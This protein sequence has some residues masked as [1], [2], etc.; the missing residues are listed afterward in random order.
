MFLRV[1]RCTHDLPLLLCLSLAPAL[2]A[3]R[4]AEAAVAYSGRGIGVRAVVG[5]GQTQTVADTGAL[6]DTGGNLSDHVVAAAVPGLLTAAIV[7]A[8]TSGAGSQSQTQASITDLAITLPG[9]AIAVDL[10]Q[11]VATA[12]CDG[13]SASVAGGATIASLTINGTPIVVNGTPNQTIAL[14]LGLGQI[15]LNQQ[16]PSASGD[17]GFIEVNALR[18]QVP[19][20]GIDVALASSHADVD[21]DAQTS[22]TAPILFSGRATV[23][24]ATVLGEHDELVDTGPLPSA[25][26]LRQSSLLTANLPGL[27]T[28][29]T[30]AA[31]TSGGGA[32]SASDATVASVALTLAGIGIS[33]DVVTSVAEASCTAGGPAASGDSVVLNL[34]I[35][36]NVIPITGTPNQVVALPLGLGQIVINEQQSTVTAS[37]AEM[38][39]AALHVIVNGIADV[40]ISRTHADVTCIPPPRAY[41]GRGVI[42]EVTTTV[43]P[44]VNTIGD[45]GALPVQGGSLSSS[46]PSI[47]LPGVL[48]ATLL[49]SSASGAADQSSAAA[50]LA[51]VDLLAGLVQATVVQSSAT[52][53]C[54]GAS[55]S[56]AGAS[57]IASLSVAGLPINVT[58]Q[59]NQVV[60]LIVGS[61][62]LNQ[63][64]GGAAGSSG[65]LTVNAL[66]LAVAGVADVVLGSS[67][68]DIECVPNALPPCPTPPAPTPTPPAP[69]PTPA[70]TAT[71]RPTPTAPLG[72]P[73]PTAGVC[74]HNCPDKIR[75]G[76][77]LDLL[78]VKSGFA[79]STVLNPSAEGFRIVLRNANGVIWQAT[80]QPGDLVLRGRKFR[81]ADKGARRGQGIRGGL[82]RVEISSANGGA[83]TRV[84]VQ[85]FADLSAATLAT[86]TVEIT[87]GNDTIAYTQPWQ[88][89][90]YGWYL[91][92]R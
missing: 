59:P 13:T 40:A 62:V 7:D 36:G 33:A 56:V 53:T 89:K 67:H 25:G 87:V 45:T 2:L 52:A 88:Q 3:G 81:F 23:F 76:S 92:H 30:L 55:A 44:L 83:G 20:L 34:V 29:A 82:S 70:V 79:P 90:P 64:T 35:A 78:D 1:L 38:N 43:P 73:Q 54:N 37:S 77:G 84:N 63:Q 22:C 69:T 74:H 11:S 17:V 10:L 48:S 21:C 66:H 80:L 4:P 58:G 42:A 51:N 65:D 60:P 61:L 12:T 47:A 75:F 19:P 46:L 91:P 50:Q 24:D 8:T 5:G 86:M 14:P 32:Q 16:I 41:S 49:Q 27:L 71:P 85:A 68:A 39:V 31:S 6:P 57:Q 26:G 18:L 9:V 28:A 15:V 72:P